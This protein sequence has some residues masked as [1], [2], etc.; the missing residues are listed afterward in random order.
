[1]A[2]FFRNAGY[3]FPDKAGCEAYVELVD[4][5]LA[6]GEHVD[7]WNNALH[8]AAELGTDLTGE[9]IA[10]RLPPTSQKLFLKT[11]ETT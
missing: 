2:S 1:L 11:I 4:R 5:E 6:G 10:A 8:A 9:Q 3:T 7:L